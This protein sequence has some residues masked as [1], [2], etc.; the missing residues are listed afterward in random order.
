MSVIAADEGTSEVEQDIDGHVAAAAIVSVPPKR[1][2]QPM[3]KGYWIAHVDVSDPETYDKYRAAIQAP[4]AEF[5]GRYVV[6][7][8][9]I[10]HAEGPHRSRNVVI[11]FP[12]PEAAQACYDSPEYQEA[13][14]FRKSA[15]SSELMI[16]A[17]YD[18][19][20]PGG[21]A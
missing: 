12:S 21:S 16:I 11:E 8:G 3:P 18:G 5:G 13:A 9:E 15:A 17:G 14:K 19:P 6:R 10:S 4:L 2:M 7:G 1:K 20:Q